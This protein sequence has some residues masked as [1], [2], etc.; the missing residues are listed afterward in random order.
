MQYNSVDVCKL[1][2]FINISISGSPLMMLVLL[3]SRPAAG[4]LS[5]VTLIYVSLVVFELVTA[6]HLSF[7]DTPWT[8]KYVSLWYLGLSMYLDLCYTD[9]LQSCCF[10]EPLTLW[11]PNSPV[12]LFVLPCAPVLRPEGC[13][14]FLMANVEAEPTLGCRC[15]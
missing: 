2:L 14:T 1:L 9:N 11:W 5:S 7:R 15:S 4:V 6:S 3:Q 13:T 8:L 10:L 12:Q